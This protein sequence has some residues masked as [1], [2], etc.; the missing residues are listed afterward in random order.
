M[1]EG[2][3]RVITSMLATGVVDRLVVAIA[4]YILGAGTE[5]V[6]ELHIQ[7]VAEAIGLSNRSVHPIGDDVLLAWDV[8]RRADRGRSRQ[9]TD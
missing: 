4:P 1:V 7:R 3:A 6:G 2:G 8:R 5:A 9:T